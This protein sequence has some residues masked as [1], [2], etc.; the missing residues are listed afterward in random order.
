MNHGTPCPSAEIGKLW[1]KV[2]QQTAKTMW[3]C[4]YGQSGQHLLLEDRQTQCTV[5]NQ[6]TKDAIVAN[7]S[8]RELNAKLHGMELKWCHEKPGLFPSHTQ[9]MF[10]TVRSRLEA[11]DA[12]QA[13]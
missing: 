11:H 8:I 7:T 6:A 13:N 1:G 12:K 3:Q 10:A 2:M 4:N 5:I 9:T